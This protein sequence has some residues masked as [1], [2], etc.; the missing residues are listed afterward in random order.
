MTL[1]PSSLI[2]ATCGDCI[3]QNDT[4][5]CVSYRTLSVK[6]RF[7]PSQTLV[8]D[9][10]FQCKANPL[11]RRVISASHRVCRSESRPVL[12]GCAEAGAR[13]NTGQYLVNP[14]EVR[15]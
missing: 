12:N 13:K 1:R 4:I 8:R 11:L 5:P 10:W 6:N 15:M 9:I 7:C 3:I 2:R 14:T